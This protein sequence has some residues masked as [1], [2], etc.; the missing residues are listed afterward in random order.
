MFLDAH[1]VLRS[2]SSL[3]HDEVAVTQNILANGFLLFTHP[4]ETAHHLPFFTFILH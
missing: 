2:D 3:E 4:A 1:F